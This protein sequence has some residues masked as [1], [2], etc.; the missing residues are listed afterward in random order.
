MNTMNLTT[1]HMSDFIRRHMNRYHAID[2]NYL[3][4]YDI[5]TLA[6]QELDEADKYWYKFIHTECVL[7]GRSETHKQRALARRKTKNATNIYNMLVANT[8][9][10]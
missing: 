3:S 2:D 6:G 1:S 10:E 4:V 5:E 8:S 9:A 7:C